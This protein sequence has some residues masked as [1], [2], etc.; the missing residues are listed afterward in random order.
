MLLPQ[1]GK[2]S[3]VICCFLSLTSLQCL[4]LPFERSRGRALFLS[5]Y[6]SR[7][8]RFN[9]RNPSNV[10]LDKSF[11]LSLPTSE[12][13]LL[14]LSSSL[15]PKCK[16][17]LTAIEIHFSFI[18]PRSSVRPSVLLFP[19]KIEHIPSLSPS[20]LPSIPKWHLWFRSLGGPFPTDDNFE[21]FR[22]YPLVR[23]KS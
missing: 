3:T 2:M 7:A 9:K 17:C 20:P 11:P 23:S 10:H 21:I 15:S 13:F 22:F 8:R 6:L 12:S 19:P 5:L 16:T 14:L 4:H 1:F 18:S